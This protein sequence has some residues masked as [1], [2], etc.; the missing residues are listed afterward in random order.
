[1]QK[2]SGPEQIVITLCRC[3]FATLHLILTIYH[4]PFLIQFDI[5]MLSVY[6]NISG[7]KY[8]VNYKKIFSLELN[9][10]DT[11]GGAD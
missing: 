6:Y 2:S 8:Q 1:M 10:V 9:D 11:S 5:R 7:V 3:S 4:H